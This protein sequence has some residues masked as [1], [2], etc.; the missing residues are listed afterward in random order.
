MAKRTGS[1]T[2]S[3]AQY[4]SGWLK[5][6]RAAIYDEAPGATLPHGDVVAMAMGEPSTPGLVDSPSE[7]RGYQSGQEYGALVR[8]AYNAGFFPDF[9]NRL[10]GGSV[11][12]V[13][14]SAGAEALGDFASDPLGELGDALGISF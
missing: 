5:G 11:V 3:T 7:A 8:T 10:R 1:N 12:A 4:R 2:A 14:A 9:E 6:F 13:A